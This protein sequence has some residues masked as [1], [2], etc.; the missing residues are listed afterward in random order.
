MR[1][2]WRKPRRKENG[3]WEVGLVKKEGKCGSLSSL[4]TASVSTPS[5]KGSRPHKNN[6][7]A[8]LWSHYSPTRTSCSAQFRS[9]AVRWAHLRVP[10][11][12][13]CGEWLSRSHAL[14]HIALDCP[15]V[16]FRLFLVHSAVPNHLSPQIAVVPMSSQG[17][18][19]HASLGNLLLSWYFWHLMRSDWIFPANWVLPE[20][21]NQIPIFRWLIP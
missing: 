10:S 20:R 2:I 14:L 17:T 6:Q 16:G 21:R 13:L 12:H 19:C 11:P 5:L 1:K 4:V 18:E 8:F 9:L 15:L 3:S 7:A